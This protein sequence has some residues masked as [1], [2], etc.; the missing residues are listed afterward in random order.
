MT[1]ISK[2]PPPI[3]PRRRKRLPRGTLRLNARFERK[4][5]TQDAKDDAQLMGK[6]LKIVSGGGSNCVLGLQGTPANGVDLPSC[7]GWP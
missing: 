1:T 7:H 2:P 4:E 5:A 3:P 6:K